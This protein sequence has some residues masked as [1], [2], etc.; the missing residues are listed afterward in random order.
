MPLRRHLIALFCL[1]L[2][3]GACSRLDLGYRHLDW[4]I[5]WSLDDYLD[6]SSQQ[7]RWLKPRLQ[8][9]LRW[10]CSTQLPA[11]SAWLQR[12]EELAGQA[13]VEPEQFAAQFDQFRQALDAVFIQ[14]TPTLSELLG[15]LS[16]LQVQHL[17]QRMA[18]EDQQLR[19]DFLDPPPEQQIAERQERMQERLQPWFGKLS[20]QQQALLAHWAQQPELN[21]QDWFDNRARWQQAFAATV[22]DRRGADFAQRLQH[23]L[24]QRTEFWTPAYREQFERSQTALAE[25]FAGLI[26]SADA[27]QRQR[28]QQ[29][30]GQLREDLDGLACVSPAEPAVASRSE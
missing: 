22:D 14:F 6:L 25:L 26:N 8:Q 7:K 16:P 19:E 23:L 10:H 1:C 17:R 24:Q 11:Y 4:L 9:H 15:G 18:E 3:L 13:Q 21:N 29:R 12:S 28:L 20:E 5:S 30:L 2:L 27:K